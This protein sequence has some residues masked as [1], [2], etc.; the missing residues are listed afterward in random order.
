MSTIPA[1]T[2]QYDID[3]LF[4]NRWSPRSFSAEP[5]DDETLFRLFEAARWAPSANNAQPWRFIYAKRDSPQWP[6]FLGF[7]GS[8]NR[9]W[10]SNASAL[11]LLVSKTTHA[12]NGSGEATP[13][14]SHSLDSGAAWASLA[15]QAEN[16][17]WRTHAIGGF[18]RQKARE[19]AQV[20]DGFHVE[21]TIAVGRQADASALAEEFQV[22]EKPSE[23]I[24]VGD[25]V[26]EGT[27]L[28][29]Q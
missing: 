21:V 13:L 14:L 29:D 24:P 20:P 6:E 18:D 8:R 15:F 2:P 10:A 16:L 25:L 17:G 19:V 7:L 26:A 11:I 4:V 27:F 12:R 9:Q 23:R 5:I 3:P 22:R 1:R 28:F